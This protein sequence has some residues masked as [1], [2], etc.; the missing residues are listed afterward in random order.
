[1]LNAT[2]LETTAPTT[3]LNAC[4]A[5]LRG[6]VL[7]AIAFSI[8][9]LAV[10][11]VSFYSDRSLIDQKIRSAI[12]DGTIQLPGGWDI[13]DPRGLDT[14]TDCWLLESLNLSPDR[15]F[16]SLFSTYVYLSDP[17]DHSCKTLS[18][19]YE[20]DG[21]TKFTVRN[22]SRYWWG[23]ATLTKIALGQTGLSLAQ[24]RNVVFYSL[25]LSLGF[26]TLTFYQSF[27]PASLFFTPYL[28]S[29]CF[30]FSLRIVPV[31]VEIGAAGAVG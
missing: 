29:V 5:L 11:T 20:N 18:L 13:D 24:Y 8:F 9:V 30:G 10:G 22:Y 19:S 7:G 4:K 6:A 23:S 27:R 21:A 26:F 31:P 12:Q 14:F 25:I 1:M 16:H 3:R 17:G 28:I 2:A 15:F